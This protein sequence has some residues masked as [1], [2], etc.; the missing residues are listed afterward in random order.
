MLTDMTLAAFSDQAAAKEPTPGGGSVA[1]YIGSLGAALG[2]MAARY[3][4][5]RKGFEGHT[6]A[7]GQEIDQLEALRGRLSDLVD[8]DAAAYTTVTG[9]YKLPKG[10]PE[11]KAARKEAIQQALGV[12]LQPPLETCRAAV[13]GL[14]VLD[15]LRRHANPN[16][17]SDV[18]VGAYALGATYRCAWINVLINLSGLTDEGRRTAITAEGDGLGARAAVLEASI[19]QQVVE[20]LTS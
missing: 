7:L 9:A 15:S 19:G 14:E 3:T 16:L 5:G 11:Q 20:G 4:E 10:G 13:A 12:A 18:A 8:A 1:A 17:I 2:C 6:E